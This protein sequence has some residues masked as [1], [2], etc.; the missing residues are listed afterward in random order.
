MTEE[1]NAAPPGPRANASL[2]AVPN[3]PDLLLFGGE[4]FNGQKCRFFDDLYR[5]NTEKNE[6]RRFTSPTSPGPRSAHQLVATNTG[7]AWLLGG[8]FASQ[9]ESQFFHYRDFWCLDLK[10]NQWEKHDI[11]IKPSARSGHRMVLWKHFFLLFGGFYD[12]LRETRYFDD[13]W[14]FDTNEISW[15]QI[16]FREVDLKPG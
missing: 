11:K 1:Q 6:W 9:S 14:V 10:T 16:T 15:K 4:F 12:A 8:E 7:K 5:Y 3:T 13:L 2:I